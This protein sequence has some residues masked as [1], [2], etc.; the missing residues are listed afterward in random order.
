M[1]NPRIL[2]VVLAVLLVGTLFWLLGWNPKQEEVAALDEDI[3]AA[4]AQQ[5]Q[6]E[7]R[8]RELR[9]VREEAPEVAALIAASEAIVPSDPALPSALRQLQLAAA[10]ANL[11]LRSVS[12][13]RAQLV[14]Q[15]EVTLEPG[16]EL[17]AFD[18]AVVV[19]GSYFQVVDFLRRVEDPTITPRGLRWTQL[20]AAQKEDGSYPLL[21]VDLV[22]RVYSVVPAG[23]TP[24]EPASEP[25]AS[26]G[27]TSEDGVE[28]EANDDADQRSA[29]EEAG[30]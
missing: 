13:G 9:L 29:D 12:P 18:V 22:G 28:D 2:L 11:T 3:A 4:Q 5:A 26:D 6:L 1:K 10:D 24:E 25:G 14:E 8:I 7:S 23:G 30:A 16:T 20:S 17:V 27:E 21:L 15:T 19:E